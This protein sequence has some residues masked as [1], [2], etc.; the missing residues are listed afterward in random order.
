MNPLVAQVLGYAIVILLIIIVI[1]FLQR[2]FFFKYFRVRGSL[3]R[4]VLIKV[5]EINIDTYAVG[6]ING[7]TLKFKNNKEEHIICIKDRN[8]FY[9]SIGIIWV[10]Y[11]SATNGLVKPDF[12]GVEGFDA[13]K[14]NNLYLRALYKPAITDNFDKILMLLMFVCLILTIVTI[15]LSVKNGNA[16]TSLKI[17]GVSVASGSI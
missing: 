3:G 14:Y 13:V 10:D 4:L 12:M 8:V 16:I 5:R 9:R 6:S 7:D 17:A 1:S 15:V 2:G 11:D